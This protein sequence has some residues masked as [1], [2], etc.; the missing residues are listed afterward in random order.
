MKTVIIERKR[1]AR[2]G[3]NGL[4]SLLNPDGNMCCLGFVAVSLGFAT[5]DINGAGDWHEMLNSD[6]N[7]DLAD[8]NEACEPFMYIDEGEY[9]IEPHLDNTE[10]S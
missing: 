8:G 3:L 7:L 9:D 4:P 10:L 5:D 1:W 2:G 6:E